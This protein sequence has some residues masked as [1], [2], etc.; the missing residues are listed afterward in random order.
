MK[1]CI[2][3]LVTAS[4]FLQGTAQKSMK[5]HNDLFF[6][7]LKGSVEKVKEIPHSVDSN[8][9]FGAAD[10]C[11]VSILAYNK[12]GYR[13]MDVSEDALGNGMSGQVY[14]KRYDNGK[15]KEI[16]LMANGRVVST[17]LATPTRDGNYGT[18][19]IYDTAGKLA[20]FYAEVEVNK[21]GKII[22]MKSF[23]PDS[24]LQQTIVNNYQEQIWVGGSIK[25]SS[26]KE[27]IAT[28]I[29]LNEKLYPSEVVQTQPMNGHPSVTR[30]KYVYDRFDGHGNWIERREL[31]DKGELRKIVKREIRYRKG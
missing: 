4:A 30:T 5:L 8:G 18:A 26:G 10:S 20:F 6:D 12:R 27:V 22:S 25:D 24:T 3:L 17:L 29:T 23:K 19:R 28:V 7:N 15:P 11:C 9:K 21:Y 13:T 14:I 16:Q 31:N 2:L 1:K